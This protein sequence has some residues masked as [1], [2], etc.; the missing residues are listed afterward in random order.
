MLPYGDQPVPVDEH[1]L[2]K[3]H[4]VAPRPVDAV[5]GA[6]ARLGDGVCILEPVEPNREHDAAR[7]LGVWRLVLRRLL[8]QANK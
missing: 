5:G 2:V 6:S 1:V 7:G 8:L 3:A 4:R